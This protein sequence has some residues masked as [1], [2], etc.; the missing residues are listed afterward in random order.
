MQFEKL[1]INTPDS[2]KLKFL[3]GIISKNISLQNDF[4]NFAQSEQ[5]VTEVFPMTSFTELL[6]STKK[7][8]QADFE[9]VD[10]DNPDWDNYHAP[11]SGY[12]EEWE[13]YQQASEQEFEGIFNAFISEAVNK[14][15]GQ[16]PFELVAMLIGLLNLLLCSL[17]CTRLHRMLKLKMTWNLLRM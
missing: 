11:H 6:S 4:I 10:T 17:D 16:K 3:N 9:M 2:L 8:Y 13:A 15:I 7:R 1:Y 5:K 14:I 12:I